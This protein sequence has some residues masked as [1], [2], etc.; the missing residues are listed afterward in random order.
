M[1][2]K[3]RYYE[4]KLVIGEQLIPTLESCLVN[5]GQMAESF[6]AEK[7]AAQSLLRKQEGENQDLNLWTD[8]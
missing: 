7:W 2:N 4:L 8:I 1:K 5:K 3:E 6:N